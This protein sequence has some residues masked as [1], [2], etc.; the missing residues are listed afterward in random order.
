MKK[1]GESLWGALWREGFAAITLG[2]ELAIPIFG[3]VLAG[4]Y[5]DRWLGTGHVFTLGLLTMGI[6]AGFYNLWRFG[7]RMAE[8]QRQIEAETKK[9]AEEQRK[10]ER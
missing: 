8:R 2:W 10:R 5:L 6:A 3:G 7:Q 9:E 1:D 4:Y